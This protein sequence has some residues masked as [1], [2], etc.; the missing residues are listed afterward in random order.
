LVKTDNPIM[1]IYFSS[2]SEPPKTLRLFYIIY[3]LIVSNE[4]GN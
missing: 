2:L 3:A 1:A 4:K